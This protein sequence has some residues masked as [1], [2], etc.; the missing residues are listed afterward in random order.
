MSIMTSNLYN[1]GMVYL[2]GF[3]SGKKKISTERGILEIRGTMNT[4]TLRVRRLSARIV[5]EQK[6]AKEAVASGNRSLAKSHLAVVVDLENRRARYHQQLLTLET[7]LLNVEE[8]KSQ[9]DVLKAFATANTALAEARTLLSPGDIQI[10]LDRLT[11]SFEHVS[12]ASEMLSENII[13]VDEGI[14]AD[15]QIDR[16]LQAIEAEVLLE[17]ERALPSL[18]TDNVREPVVGEKH[19]EMEINDLLTKLGQRTEEEKHRKVQN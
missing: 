14:S 1:I 9:S 2:M 10:Q 3:L 16:R 18:D 11:E 7:A 17:K 12:L 6:A 8:A 4:I 13:G 5:E 15:Q 19:H